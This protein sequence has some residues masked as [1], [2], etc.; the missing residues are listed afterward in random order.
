MPALAWA[1]CFL[2]SAGSWASPNSGLLLLGN[3]ASFFV[4]LIVAVSAFTCEDTHLGY[5]QAVHLLNA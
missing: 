2:V 5:P 3:G 1:F 4:A